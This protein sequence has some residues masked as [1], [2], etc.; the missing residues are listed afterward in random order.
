MLI[1][2]LSHLAAS[3]EF[4]VLNPVPLWRAPMRPTNH[5]ARLCLLLLLIYMAMWVSE[6]AQF[7]S[8]FY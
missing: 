5:S 2:A 3:Q 7:L 8:I 4:K 1:F 6:K